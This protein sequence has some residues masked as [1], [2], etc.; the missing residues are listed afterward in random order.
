MSLKI[1]E[2]L[3]TDNKNLSQYLLERGEI[4]FQTQLDDNFKKV[5]LLSAASNLEHQITE[6]ITEFAKKASGNCSSLVSFIKNKAISRQFHTYFNWERNNAN[7][8]FGLFGTELSEQ[9]KNDVSSQNDLEKSV[10]AFLEIG[11]LRNTM[12]H[13]DFV[14]FNFN[15]TAEEVFQLYVNSQSFV[16]Y[17]S[18]KLISSIPQ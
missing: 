16:K 12:V 1:I 13:E 5:L 2:K 8:F 14:S 11:D 18:E 7:Q 3:H 4:S 15:K 17:L 9:M 6:I 10:K